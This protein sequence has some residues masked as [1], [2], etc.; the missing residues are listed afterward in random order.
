MARGC[1]FHLGSVQEGLFVGC[2]RSVQKRTSAGCV[3]NA[4]LGNQRNTA[5]FLS[6]L[7]RMVRLILFQTASASP[8]H[9]GN[10]YRPT[11]LHPVVRPMFPFLLI[12]DGARKQTHPLAGDDL[13][14]YNEVRSP[15]CQLARPHR[16]VGAPES[17]PAERTHRCEHTHSHAHKTSAGF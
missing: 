15:R 8:S 13:V 12:R 3:C 9:W 11:F 6:A 10:N 14:V 4:V 16:F 2:P 7:F 17:A 5:P 1:H